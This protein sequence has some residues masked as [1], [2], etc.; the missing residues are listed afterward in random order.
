M[1]SVVETG[2]FIDEGRVQE[3][4]RAADDKDAGHVRE[5]LARARELNGLEMQDV[6]VLSSV[7]DP[8]LLGELFALHDQR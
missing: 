7:S 2:S 5:I 6:A 3:A 8:E 4:L 1:M